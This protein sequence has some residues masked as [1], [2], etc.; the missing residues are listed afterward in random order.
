MT[1]LLEAFISV[2]PNYASNKP[3]KVSR[4]C[5]SKSR[6]RNNYLFAYFSSMGFTKSQIRD[7]RALKH[8]W[9]VVIEPHLDMRLLTNQDQGR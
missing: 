5:S 1:H 7:F 9:A 2:V 6:K 3:S 8:F 4:G